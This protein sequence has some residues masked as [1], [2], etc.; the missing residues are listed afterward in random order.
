MKL[1]FYRYGSICEPDIISGF[2]ELG[3]QIEEITEEVTNKNLSPQKSIQITTDFLLE[4]KVD[5]VFSIN[6][7]PI[8]SEVCNIFKLPYLCWIVDSPVMELFT[9]SVQN[10]WNR[11]FIFDRTIYEEISPLNP[12]CVFHLPLAT[13]VA[14]KS[15]LIAGA[16]SKTQSYYTASV[17]FIGSLYTEKCAYD[18]LNS[19]ASPY[20]TG[21]LNGLMEA[22]LK[23]Y[24]YYFI[25]DVLPEEIVTEFVEHFPNFYRLPGESFL[26]DKATLAQ[27]YLGTKITV[28]ERDRLMQRLSK[29]FNV[30]I[31]T[32]SNTSAYPALTNRGLAKTLTEM[33]L[34][35]HGSNINLN[36]TAKSIR[37]G[38]PLRIWDILGSG[39]FCLTN[40]QAEIPELLQIGEHLD[41]YSC[42]DE[43]EEKTAYYLDHPD[44]RKEIAH[45][46]YEIVKNY[47]T[48]PVRL[49][50]MLALAYKGVL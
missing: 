7:F 47:H 49:E 45:T 8:L 5:F 15:E 25:E 23:V 38:L 42:F 11:I 3:L 20:L 14:Q 41:T 24:G 9:T 29:R 21:Y 27:L 46:G 16:S 37:S 30:T 48:Y 31:Y 26:T 35:F 4:H 40:Y 32:G 17:S 39:G 34:I 18:R 10:P 13:N 50:T 44:I 33:P 43:L 6:F 28:M 19:S 36:I 12:G 1:L 2:E 22:Q